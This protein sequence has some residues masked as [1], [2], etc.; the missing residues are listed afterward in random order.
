MERLAELRNHRRRGSMRREQ[1][2]PG[3]YV[4]A[5][6][7]T[8]L[9]GSRNIR[10]RRET[11]FAGHGKRFELSGLYV[12]D[13]GR[14]RVEQYIGMLAE[15]RVDGFRRCLEWNVQQIHLCGLLEHFTGKMLGRGK[16]GAGEDNLSG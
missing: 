6:K 14:H 4:V 11:T 8:R 9:H 2:I 12:A 3:G 7:Y 13:Q 16:T 15:R 5:R 10:H 1:A